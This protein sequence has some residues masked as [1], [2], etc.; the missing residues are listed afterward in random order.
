[1]Q[2]KLTA[3][4]AWAV[5]PKDGTWGQRQNTS[6]V[7]CSQCFYQNNVRTSPREQQGKCQEI[8]TEWIPHYSLRWDIWT[9]KQLLSP[10]VLATHYNRIK[11][12]RPLHHPLNQGQQC[13][14]PQGIKRPVSIRVWGFCLEEEEESKI[15]FEG[16]YWRFLNR[17]L[18][19]SCALVLSLPSL[20]RQVPE[21]KRDQDKLNHI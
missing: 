2:D 17:G 13:S 18:S 3:R 4:G 7:P 19:G 1:M 12:T 9:M 14:T 8:S 5:P 10:L 6:W 15:I 11:H 20:P 16:H 21:H